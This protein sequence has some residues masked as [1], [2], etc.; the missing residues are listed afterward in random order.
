MNG[1]GVP[2]MKKIISM[3]VA[4]WEYRGKG[5]STCCHNHFGLGTDESAV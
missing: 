1:W 3:K 5:Q 4:Q 2:S